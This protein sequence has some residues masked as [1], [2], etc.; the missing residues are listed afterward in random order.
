MQTETASLLQRC[1]K[2]RL[3]MTR[4]RYAIVAVIAAS[5]DH[6][7]VDEVHRRVVKIDT[8][9]SLSTVYR[10]L[11]HFAGLGLIE[12][13]TFADGRVRVERAKK[14]HHDHLIDVTTGAVIEF[15]SDEIERLQ[16]EIALKHGYQLTGHKLELYGR[17]FGKRWNRV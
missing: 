3:R 7:D 8:R 10:T 2:L 14:Q 6:P 17:P 15:R 1:Q 11:R 5:D 13:H 9:V 4:P 16:R 12:S